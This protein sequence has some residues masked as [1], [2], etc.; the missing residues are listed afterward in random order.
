MV[1]DNNERERERRPNRRAF[2]RSG[3][4]GIMPIEHTHRDKDI[5]GV[6]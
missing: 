6:E 4:V 1:N 2:V 5:G 3:L